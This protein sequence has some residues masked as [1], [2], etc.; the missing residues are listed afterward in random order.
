MQNARFEEIEHT[1]DVGIKGSAPSLPE[2]FANFAFGMYHLIVGSLSPKAEKT[3]FLQIT[4]TT[5]EDLLVNWLSE[6]NY[7]FVVHHFI[8]AVF[9]DLF[10]TEKGAVYVLNTKLS[11]EDVRK[12]KDL[13]KTEIK[14]VTWH[15]LYLKET[16]TGYHA[17][18]IFDV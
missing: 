15:Q 4:G 18:V 5:F 14:A 12:Y 10:I 16:G 7:L 3:K 17:Q 11:G 1:A 9:S 2:L 8:S 6:L 13:I